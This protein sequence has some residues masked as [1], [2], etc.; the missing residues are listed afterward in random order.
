MTKNDNG[1][2]L[3]KKLSETKKAALAQAGSVLK[4][5]GF[6]YWTICAGNSVD[7][8]KGRALRSIASN[9]HMDLPFSTCAVSAI[10]QVVLQDLDTPKEQLAYLV[11]I[12]KRTLAEVNPELAQE[13]N[14][15]VGSRADEEVDPEKMN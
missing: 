13:I 14:E 1:L 5:A 4:A 3:T 9:I 6:G 15:R 2:V 10:L 11:D 7:D 8:R 12:V